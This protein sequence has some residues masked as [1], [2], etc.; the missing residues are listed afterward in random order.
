MGVHRVQTHQNAQFSHKQK[1][2]EEFFGV[3]VCD[4]PGV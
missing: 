1:V 4:I 3:L 2:N